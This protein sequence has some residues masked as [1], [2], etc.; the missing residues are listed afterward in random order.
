MATYFTHSYFYE[1]VLSVSFGVLKEDDI[2]SIDA[3]I[4]HSFFNIQ[5]SKTLKQSHFLA[6]ANTV[7][8]DLDFKQIIKV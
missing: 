5:L 7:R 8:M 6:I 4:I 1:V 2:Y 3:L